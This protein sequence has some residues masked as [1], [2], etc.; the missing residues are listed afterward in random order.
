MSSKGNKKSDKKRWRVDDVEK[1]LLKHD[2]NLEK[3]CERLLI[4]LGT[5]LFEFAKNEYEKAY[6]ESIAQVSKVVHP[7]QEIS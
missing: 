2:S 4:A 7:I 5:Y 1:L 6:N 3:D